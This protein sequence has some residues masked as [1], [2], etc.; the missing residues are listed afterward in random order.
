[1]DASSGAGDL[2]N[3]LYTTYLS[4]VRKSMIS[5]ASNGDSLSV[6]IRRIVYNPGVLADFSELSQ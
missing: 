5:F 6:V 1:M 3:A 2:P 4:R